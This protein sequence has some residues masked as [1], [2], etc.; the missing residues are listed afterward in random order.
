MEHTPLPP[1]NDLQIAFLNSVVLR[2]VLN[3]PIM[4]TNI[5]REFRAGKTDWE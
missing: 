3:A 2:E 4:S 5:R 1:L